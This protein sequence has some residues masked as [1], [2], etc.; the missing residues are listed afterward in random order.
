MLGYTVAPCPTIKTC[1]YSPTRKSSKVLWTA[2]ACRRVRG[3]HKL[4]KMISNRSPLVCVFLCI[5]VTCNNVAQ[6]FS[7]NILFFHTFVTASHRTAIW[8]LAEKLANSGHNVTYIF[9][10][11]KRYNHPKIEEIVPSRMVSILSNFVSE[12]DINI[13]LEN[14]VEEWLEDVLGTTVE[15]CD[16]FFDSPEIQ[17]WMSRPGLHY[18]LMLLDGC[19]SECGYSLVHKFKSKYILFS[20]IIVPFFYDGLGFVPESSSNPDVLFH[21]KPTQMTLINRVKTTLTYL[22]WRLKF[23][24]YMGS[25]EEIFKRKI[26]PE[27]PS[28]FDIERNVSLVMLNSYLIEEYPTSLPPM[29][30]SYSGLWC[31]RDKLKERKSLPKEMEE[32]I[33]KSEGFFYVSFGSATT[34]SAMPIQMRNKFFQAFSAFPKVKFFWR[35]TGSVPDDTPKNV[36]LKSWFPQNDI[37]G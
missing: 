23:T 9:P 33:G 2:K 21:S 15:L 29:F 12:F 24:L 16:A 8:P 28:I 3:I 6:V 32:F 1:L 27:F 13:R 22:L 10:M 7:A 19:L 26:N 20:P 25:I 11:E 37:L 31:S 36:L 17:E 14:K 30:V 34:A 4:F 35:W 18:D 5:L